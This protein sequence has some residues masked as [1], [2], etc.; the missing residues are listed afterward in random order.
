[1]NQAPSGVTS[2]EYAAP[3]GLKIILVLGST[4]M[5]RLTALGT[6]AVPKSFCVGRLGHLAF[7][8]SECNHLFHQCIYR[9]FPLRC[10]MIHR[11]Q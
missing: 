1:M 4:N 8:F 6:N 11:H 10:R 9:Q 7:E 3:T 5:P 2:S